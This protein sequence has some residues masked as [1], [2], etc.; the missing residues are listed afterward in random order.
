MAAPK[1]TYIFVAINR[2]QT[3]TAPIMLRVTATDEKSARQRFVSDYVLLAAYPHIGGTMEQYELIMPPTPTCIDVECQCRALAY[4]AYHIDH[5]EVCSGQ[6]KLATALE[7]F[8]N[9]R[10]DSFG[11]KP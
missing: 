5:P 11:V 1:C 4:A 3:K 2:I 7:F 6:Q 10:S 8:Q 9:N